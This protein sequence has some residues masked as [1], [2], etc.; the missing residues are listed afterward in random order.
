MKKKLF[1]MRLRIAKRSARLHTYGQ[2][3]FPE[4]GGDS[5]LTIEQ[6]RPRMK[7]KLLQFSKKEEEDDLPRSILYIFGSTGNIKHGAGFWSRRENRWWWIPAHFFMCETH[8]FFISQPAVQF[9]TYGQGKIKG[10]G[11]PLFKSFEL[12]VFFFLVARAIQR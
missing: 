1:P 3:S 12:P 4:G 5:G 8:L 6:I 7:I 10:N 2:R 9:G 11:R